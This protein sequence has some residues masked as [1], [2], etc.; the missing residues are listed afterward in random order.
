MQKYTAK[1]HVHTYIPSRSI[2]HAGTAAANKDYRDP[3]P[4]QLVNSGELGKWSLYRAII[5]EF[6]ATLLFVYVTLATVSSATRTNRQSRE[7]V[8]AASESWASP[9][10]LVA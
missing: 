7:R 1:Y 2:H 3:P 5:A 4:A 9:G 8:A 6:V 10:P